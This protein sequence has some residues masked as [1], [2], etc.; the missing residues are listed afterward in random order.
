LVVSH[1]GMIYW[2][3]RVLQMKLNTYFL[4][5]HLKA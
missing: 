4:I 5:A 3:E 1:I 2:V